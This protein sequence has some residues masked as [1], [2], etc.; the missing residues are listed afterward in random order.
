MLARIKKEWKHVGTRVTRVSCRQELR[1]NRGKG[2][3]IGKQ[4]EVGTKLRLGWGARDE[5]RV[6]TIT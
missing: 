6:K 2:E 1:G 4:R 3:E 5:G